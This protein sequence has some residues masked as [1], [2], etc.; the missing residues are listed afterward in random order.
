MGS[1]DN[2][3]KTMSPP[4]LKNKNKSQA[5]LDNHLCMGLNNTGNMEMKIKLIK[6]INNIGDN[7]LAAFD[8][9]SQNMSVRK[10][11]IK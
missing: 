2:L 7:E 10:E 5:D 6:E 8:H 4:K 1:P 11:Q 3:A 9:L